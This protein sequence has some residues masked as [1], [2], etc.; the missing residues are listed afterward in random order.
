MDFA[1]EVFDV[2]EGHVGKIVGL[3][4]A[5]N[6][7]DVVEFGRVFG[8]PLDAQPMG[9]GRQGRAR[10]LAGVNGAVVQDQHDGRGAASRLRAVEP[11]QLFEMGDEIAA[12]LG[13]AGVDDEFADRVIERAQ[14]RDFFRL[15]RCGDTQVC[16]RLRP[17]AGEVGMRQ[18]LALI[19]IE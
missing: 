2:V 17:G 5:P 15:S 14:Q 4:I 3:Q 19:A 18:R 10:E 7:L 6:C 13:R 9:A 12:A 11:V 1:V 16:A 8:Q